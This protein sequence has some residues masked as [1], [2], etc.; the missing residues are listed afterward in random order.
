[1]LWNTW[2]PRCPVA[3][4]VGKNSIRSLCFFLEGNHSGNFEVSVV[5]L[6]EKNS[7]HFGVTKTCK[8][9]RQ[10]VLCREFPPREGKRPNLWS[11]P[12]LVSEDTKM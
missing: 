8:T 12:G 2:I 9:C 11:L 1:M 3:G 5:F 4:Q 7:G 10:L 6:G